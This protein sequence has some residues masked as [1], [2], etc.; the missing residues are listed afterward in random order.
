MKINSQDSNEI[1]SIEEMWT[2]IWKYSQYDAL[3]SSVLTNA[4]VLNKTREETAIMLAFVALRKAED[5]FDTL[6]EI[7]RNKI[8]SP[9]KLKSYVNFLPK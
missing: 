1:L 7:K 3:T 2:H 6:V 5:Y 8:N 9:L 4:M